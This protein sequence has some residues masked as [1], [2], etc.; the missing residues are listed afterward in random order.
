MISGYQ[1]RDGSNGSVNLLVTGRTT[2]P[3]WIPRNEPTGRPNTVLSTTEE[4]PDVGTQNFTLGHYIEDNAYKGDLT[5]LSFYDEATA[6]SRVFNATTDYDLNEYNVRWCVTPEFPEGTWAYFTCIDPDGLAVFPY[7]MSR[8]HYGVLSGAD[9]VN[10]PNNRAVIF[11]GGPEAKQNVQSVAVDSSNGDV[12]LAWSGVEGGTYLI[13]NSDDLTNWSALNDDAR[14]SMGNLATSKD[15]SRSASDP[16]HFYRSTMLSLKPFDDAGYDYTAP[17][18]PTFRAEFSPLPDLDDITSATINGVE[19]TILGSDGDT[20]FLEFD[21]ASLPPGD[22]TVNIN[23]TPAGNTTGGELEASSTNT[24]TVA[25]PRNVL[26]MIVDDWGLDSNPLDDLGIPGTTFPSMP[27][28]QFLADHGLSFSNAYAQPVCAPTRASIITGRHGFRHGVGHP[29]G[30]GTLNTDELTLPE[31]FTAQNS[32]YSIASFGKWHLGGGATGP[33]T[34]GGWP[35]FRG[36]LTNIP[37]YFNWSKVVN[38]VTSTS[39]DYVT[40]DQVDDTVSFI[41]A[42]TNPWFVWLAFSAPHSPYHNPPSH[43]HDYPTFATNNNGSVSGS[44]QRAAYEASLQALDTEI[45]RLL[46]TVD[47]STTNIIIIGDNGTP[48]D[49]VQAP[50]SEDHSKDTLYEGGVRV[51]MIAIGPDVKIHG[52]SSK[53]VHCV[54]IFSTVL[55]IAGIDITRATASVDVIDSQSLLPIFKGQDTA[56]RCIVAE[57]HT[58]TITGVGASLTGRAIRLASH[59]DYKLIVFGDPTTAADTSTFEM[60]HI[61]EDINEQTPLSIPAAIGEPHYLAYTAL[62]AKELEIGPSAPVAASDEI[63]FIEL[64]DTI[65][66]SQSVPGQT[67]TDPLTIFVDGVEATFISR[68][69]TSE[70]IDRYWVKCSLPDDSGAPYSDTAAVVSFPP[71]TNNDQGNRVFTSIQ[72]IANP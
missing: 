9:E 38:G 13:E 3:A 40:T 12:T 47:L 30:S 22:Y 70:V 35:E 8:Y 57:R 50:Y 55:E 31:I 71:N 68:V 45:G 24:H 18:T 23:F 16:Q 66:G 10:L 62:M 58:T 5:G 11:E 48:G 32:P 42:E 41:N 19:V 14:T 60:Y 72:I 6:N 25:P 43:L 33:A 52:N 34:I 61:T 1:R 44:D 29:S 65:T 67:G 37:D 28:L 69:N 64:P 54:D 56:E 53:I 46:E 51:P 15:Q 39:T 63:L 27:N 21:E 2:V 17:V 59:P 36:Y 20:L 7:A 49:V 26:L 4:G